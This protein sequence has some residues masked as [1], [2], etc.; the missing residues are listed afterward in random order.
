MLLDI[1]TNPLIIS[2]VLAMPVSLLRIELPE[3]LTRSVNS[4]ASLATPIAL[5]CLGAQ[6]D[7]KNARQ[8]LRRTLPAA[9]LKQA[10]IPAVML[11]IAVA[12]GFR[13]GELGAL[14]IV[15]MAPSSVSSYIMAKNMR[16]DAQL[17]AQMILW[18]TLLSMFTMFLGIYILR[19]L[20]CF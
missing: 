5:L 16:S 7:W 12:F 19:S 1:V 14:F 11:S 4:V 15:F 10:V 2:I 8:N 9:L 3:M 17:A 6:F 20:N 13:G 18:T